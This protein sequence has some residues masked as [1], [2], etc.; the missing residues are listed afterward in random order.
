MSSYPDHSVFTRRLCAFVRNFIRSPDFFAFMFRHSCVHQTFLHS[1]DFRAFPR[2]WCFHLQ[3]C[4]RS[5][6]FCALIFTFLCIHQTFM[7]SPD[8]C[9]ITLRLSCVHQNFVPSQNFL[10]FHVQNFV[11]SCT[12]FH[13]IRVRET[14]TS[15]NLNT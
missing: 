4:V 10:C 13:A 11:R 15:Y 8:F 9:A 3:I 5:A 14:A 6:G 2:L 12:D 7:L 1:T